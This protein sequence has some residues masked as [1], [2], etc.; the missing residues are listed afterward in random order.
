MVLVKCILFH[1]M[2]YYSHCF[3]S[4]VVLQNCMDL[5]KPE[6]GSYSD[7]SLTSSH[8]GNEISGIK[9]EEVTDIAKEENQESVTP[10]VLK[11]EPNVSFFFGVVRI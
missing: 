8:G 1:V 4:L 7:S 9:V 6:H 10:E 11:M 2:R 3:K 5:L